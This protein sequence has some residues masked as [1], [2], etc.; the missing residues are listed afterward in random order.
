MVAEQMYGEQPPELSVEEQM[1][2]VKPVGDGRVAF[3]E[4]TKIVEKNLVREFI[5]EAADAPVMSQRQEPMN[6]KEV[7]QMQYVGKI[8]DVPV[9]AQHQVPT[10][11]AVQKA[12]EVPR[13]QFRDRVVDVPVV[14][15]RQ[16][17]L[18]RILERIVEETDVPGPHVREVDVPDPPIQEETVEVIPLTRQNQTPGRVRDEIAEL[19]GDHKKFYEQ[20]VKCMKLGI[21]GN[22]VDDF[23]IAKLLRF[24][25]S[26][27]GDEQISFKEY[28]DCMKEGQYGNYH[29]TGESIAVMSSWSF[30]EYWRKKSYEVLYVADPVDEYAVQQ[31]EEFDGTKLKQTTKEGLDLGDQDE[32]KT[33]E[34]LNIESEPLRKLMKE[35]LGDKVEEESQVAAMNCDGGNGVGVSKGIDVGIALL[36]GFW[37]CRDGV[38]R[39]E[40]GDGSSWAGGRRAYATAHRSSSVAAAATQQQATTN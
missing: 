16:V 38:G 1:V 32:K 19:N 24:N 11:Q 15:R 4:A 23:E 17:L 2:G 33:I 40:K 18:E 29:I 37:R 13:V 10:V 5:D 9:V 12:V 20:F 6:Q 3:A 31:L 8:I 14:M 22:S 26:K 25:T 7:P 34:E 21:R 35:A 30:R 36:S 28:V 39:A 27:S